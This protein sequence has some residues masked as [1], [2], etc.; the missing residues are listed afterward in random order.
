VLRAPCRRA[1]DPDQ[2]WEQRRVNIHAEHLDLRRDACVGEAGGDA[3]VLDDRL[4]VDYQ[5]Q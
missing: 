1:A 5:P 4:C 3:D 2:C